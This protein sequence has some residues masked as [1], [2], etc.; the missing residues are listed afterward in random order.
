MKSKS[1][2]SPYFLL[3]L[4]VILLVFLY[5]LYRFYRSMSDATVRESFLGIGID[6]NSV[7]AWCNSVDSVK[8]C[9]NKPAHNEGLEEKAKKDPAVENGICLTEDGEWGIQLK[10]YGRKCMSMDMI[11]N[12][13]NNIQAD[14]ASADNADNADNQNID[15]GSGLGT[16]A[17]GVA[18]VAKENIVF[19]INM[20]RVPPIAGKNQ[21][22]CIELANLGYPND[23]KKRIEV[24]DNLCRNKFG[25]QFGLERIVHCDND[26]KIISGVC[27]PNYFNGQKIESNITPVCHSYTENMDTICRK[28]MNDSFMMA[29]RVFAGAQGGCYRENNEGTYDPD[30][31]KVR[32]MCGDNAKPGE[33]P[34]IPWQSSNAAFEEECKKVGGNGRVAAKIISDCPIGKRRAICETTQPAGQ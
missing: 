6:V 4:V 16:A 29:T 12:K 28:Q 21:T 14:A 2:N 26:E 18:G 31:G 20:N 27:S 10:E 3:F 13:Q 11:R 30:L 22:D 5:I 9:I 23:P 7:D 15:D 25:V 34:C 1:P 33:T 32:I 19:G 8:P 17:A 24:L